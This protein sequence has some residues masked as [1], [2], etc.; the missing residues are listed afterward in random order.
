VR[1]GSDAAL[2]AARRSNEL[3][4]AGDAEGCAVWKRIIEAV[5]KLLR[6]EPTEG[7]QVTKKSR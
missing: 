1:H 4:G 3:L 7:E 2:A 5:A 6:T